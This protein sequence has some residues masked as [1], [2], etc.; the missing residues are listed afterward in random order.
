MRATV[1]ALLCVP[2]ILFAQD[3]NH[4]A[5]EAGLFSPAEMK[6]VDGP[7]SL[8]HGSKM[9]V[10][11]GDPTQE[12]PF[13]MRLRLPDGYKIPAHTHPKTER[14]TVIRGTFNIVMGD[15]LDATK[16]TKMPAGSF[17]HWPAGMRHLVWASGE[18]EVQLHG[19][20]P[21]S[22]NYVNPADDPRK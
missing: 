22:I 18:T 8:P 12:G 11:E 6:W 2:A 20:G 19:I 1:L 7:K 10:L 16:H 13:V 14:L 17:G 21:W 5:D 9:A 3:K 4:P 15:N